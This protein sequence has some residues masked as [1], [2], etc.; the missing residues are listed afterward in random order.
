MS[1]KTVSI[2]LKRDG[3]NIL[4]KG[5]FTILFLMMGLSIVGAG[6]RGSPTTA[7]IVL[8]IGMLMNIIG[9][10]PYFVPILYKTLVPEEALA[11]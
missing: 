11:T 7:P 4:T 8:V 9:V 3:M 5:F 6:L 2:Q 10:A 1:K